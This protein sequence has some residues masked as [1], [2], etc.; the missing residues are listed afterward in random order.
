MPCLSFQHLRGRGRQIRSSRSHVVSESQALGYMKLYLKTKQNKTKT[1]TRLAYL[2][3][4]SK[5]FILWYLEENYC[6]HICCYL[7]IE[8]WIFMQQTIIWDMAEKLLTLKF[9]RR[10]LREAFMSNFKFRIIVVH[11]LISEILLE[12]SN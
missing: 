8:R 3:W 6:I 1:P 11:L 9:E 10:K 2:L 12:K 4:L 5:A 7:M